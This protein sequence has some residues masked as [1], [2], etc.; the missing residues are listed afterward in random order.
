MHLEWVLHPL[1]QYAFLAAGL[2][3]CLLLNLNCQREIGAAKS[4]LGAQISAHEETLTK[5]NSELSAIR[6]RLQE[7]EEQA[8]AASAP[9]APQRGM[10]LTKRTQVLRMNRRGERPEQI[11]TALCLPL[12][13]VELL[14]K[15]HL[16]TV[17]SA[18]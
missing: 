16:V 18:A 14:L 1:T 9:S 4:R 3:L 13:E 12:S 17:E 15:L 5:L 6:E 10:N 7:V 8:K 2:C 11:A